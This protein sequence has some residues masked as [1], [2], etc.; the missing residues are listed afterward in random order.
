MKDEQNTFKQTG[1]FVSTILENFP[2]LNEVEIQY[3]IEH[4][5]EIK[6]IIKRFSNVPIL[7]I[8]QNPS[9]TERIMKGKYTD[10]DPRITEETFPILIPHDYRVQYELFHFDMVM[11]SQLV[12]E[13]MTQKG[14]RP[15]TLI[16]LLEFGRSKP[17]IQKKFPVIALGSAI[18]KG[19]G[20]C[21]VPFCDNCGSRITLASYGAQWNKACRFLAVYDGRKI[22]HISAGLSA[23]ERIK[24]GRY[25]LVGFY[26]KEA[27]L[28]AHPV[29]K[30]YEA[31]YELFHFKKEIE[32][33]PDAVER[34]Y[35]K[36]FRPANVHELLALGTAY[37]H[38][39]KKFPIIEIE[40]DE[41]E[42]LT[43][44]YDSAK[45]RSLLTRRLD[46][47]WYGILR[48]LGVRM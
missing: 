23:E 38:L 25:D 35:K 46:R 10:M 18:K 16:E 40:G 21:R 11:P 27:V 3:W 34:M 9:L 28:K 17:E 8:S 24:A 22:L 29:V 33:Y 1:K 31:E 19:D 47:E 44:D 13:K 2:K 41:L 30:D 15:A 26:V 32:Y 48:I 42:Y 43:L 36:G 37:P 7:H 5:L 6:E 4:P 12:V 14:C 39:Q 45:G 20:E